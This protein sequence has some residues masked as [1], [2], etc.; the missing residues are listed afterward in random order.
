LEELIFLFCFEESFEV[1]KV[2][3]EDLTSTSFEEQKKPL[4][5]ALRWS[6]SRLDCSTTAE[7]R[8]VSKLTQ[9]REAQNRAG[10]EREHE[11][12]K[13]IQR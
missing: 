13:A 9:Q 6:S 3:V 10:R 11:K 2:E 4:F 1:E 5:L 7:P 8:A 12:R